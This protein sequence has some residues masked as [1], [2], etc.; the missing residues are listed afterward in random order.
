M[1]VTRHILT[2]FPVALVL[3]L[4]LAFPGSALTDGG[5]NESGEEEAF[6]VP[7]QPMDLEATVQE[8]GKTVVLTWNPPLW[9]GN[10][11]IDNYRIYR[12]GGFVASVPVTVTE[13]TDAGVGVTATSV[14]H[15]TAVNSDGEGLPGFSH[16]MSFNNHDCIVHTPAGI[17]HNI[18]DCFKDFP[19]VGPIY[20]QFVHPIVKP[21]FT[22]FV[23]P[24][25]Q[26]IKD[27]WP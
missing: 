15:V 3:C 2:T 20:E 8:D 26:L 14:Y 12:E 16:P 21:V 23:D 4:I 9:G 5:W 18:P 24:V 25:W 17:D 19:A 11:P 27:N 13:F 1:G 6:P 22:Q 10:S 7:S